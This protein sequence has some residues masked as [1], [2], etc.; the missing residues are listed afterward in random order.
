MVWTYVKRMAGAL[1][2]AAVAA[3]A[4]AEE[5]TFVGWSHTEAGLKPT[6]EKLFADFQAKS[7][8]DKLNVI[9]FPFGQMEQ[10]LIL[11][12][13]TGQRTDVAQLQERWAPLFASMNALADLDQVFGKDALAGMFDADLLKLGQARGKQV[14][15]PFTVGAI[16]MI[17]N[18]KV[19]RDAG[20][21]EVPKT[22][23]EFAAALRQIRQKLPN[24]IP[25]GFSTKLTQVLQLE[26]QMWFWQFGAS[27]L[28]DKGAVVVDTP[29]AHAALRQL[30]DF[31]NEGLIAKGNDRFD[32]RKIF[33]K[34]E[35]GFFF[36]AP[37]VRGF[38]R[39]HSGEGAAWDPNLIIMPVP[40]MQAGT[41]PRAAIWGHVLSMFTQG[42]ARPT[43]DSLAGRFI[44][45]TVF[46]K[47]TQ[48]ALWR[49]GAQIPTTRAA[50]AS[51]ADDGYV[52]AF[53]A[54]AKTGG[55]DQTAFWPNGTELRQIVGEEV[56]AALL[57]QKPAD[58]AI[59][60][61]ARRLEAAMKDVR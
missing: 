44:Q 14:G 46:D 19:L 45:T 61:M 37:V 16:T 4:G 60:S 30:V 55:W 39:A 48:L 33:A 59:K 8:N 3:S 53:V 6:L 58:Q 50:L 47:D 31:V 21:A 2:I 40:V 25:F 35:V 22:N 43:R 11:R 12:H 51:L 23:A 18:A 29:Q 24:V 38:M 49:D 52:Q 57:G 5:M 27:L 7:P 13:R 26:A 10:N 32:T 42:G 54:A 36:D 15:V 17:A 41:P 56:E 34:H 20:I 9:G 28:D 1:A